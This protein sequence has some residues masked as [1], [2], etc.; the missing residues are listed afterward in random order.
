MLHVFVGVLA[1]VAILGN[2]NSNSNGKCAT[3]LFADAVAPPYPE[4]LETSR[5]HRKLH[6]SLFPNITYFSL[7]TLPS[8]IW[9][10]ASDFKKRRRL[11]R[12]GNYRALASDDKDF[13]D[14]EICRYLD[15]EAECQEMMER[16]SQMAAK[17]R[18]RIT[19]GNSIISGLR[20]FGAESKNKPYILRTLV[21]MVAWKEHENR[22]EWVSRDQVDHVW[23][24]IV[25]DDAIPTG[26][27]KHY[28]ETQSYGTVEFVA[29]VLDWRVAD[30]TEEYYAD[31]RSAMP[32]SGD[33]EPDIRTAFHKILEE[34]DSEDFPWGDYDSDNDGYVDHV[35][36]VHSGYGAELG[37]TDCYTKAKSDDRIWAH[38]LPEGRGKWTSPKTGIEL[39]G[40]SVSSVLRDKCGKEVAQLGVT[41]HEFYHTLGLP[42]LY[43]RELPY[44]GESGKSG[45]GGLGLFCMMACPFGA[46][47]NQ[48]H[49]G[50]LSP[51]SKV[52]MGFVKEP[53]EITKSGTYTARPSNGQP[54]IY[55][56]KKG[57]QDGEMLLLENR[58]NIGYDSSLWTGGILIY[59]IDETEGH[60]GNK[61]HGF[62]GQTDVPE[63]GQSWPSNGLH[64][65]IA[66][67]QADGD[68][69][70]E[71]ALNNGDRGDFFRKSNQKLGPGNG[72]LVATEEG[73]YPNTDSYAFGDIQTT[74][75]TIDDF[76][77]TPD[78]S[79]I[80][81]FRVTFADEP[82]SP[83]APPTKLPTKRPTKEPTG[84]PTEVPTQSMTKTPFKSPTKQPS[85]KPTKSPTKLP[86]AALTKSPAELP[87]K[88]PTEAPT[89]DS[90]S[91]NFEYWTS[92]PTKVPSKPPITNPPTEAPTSKQTLPF[93]SPMTTPTKVS[94]E[95]PTTKP[96][97]VAPTI[98]IET[99][100]TQSP[101]S[102]P[103]T[104]APTTRL[105]L[106]DPIDESECSHI[107]HVNITTDGRPEETKWEIVSAIT[108]QYLAG[109]R[110][111]EDL[112]PKRSLQTYTEYGWKI[113][114]WGSETS[115]IFRLHDSGFDG[116]QPPGKYSLSLNEELIA[117]GGPFVD[118]VTVEFSTTESSD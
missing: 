17:T 2:N 82:I 6:E 104:E 41:M 68:Y 31:G 92:K 8:G 94:T 56:I 71:N 5:K 13:D 50:S 32:R 4:L 24:G 95:P 93:E 114:S 47:N 113:C 34:M 76:R 29:D 25:T 85:E 77:E 51:W 84:K 106:I 21:I 10:P 48:M 67:L 96:P 38:A 52:E 66:L 59:H 101:S 20:T 99:P 45:L 23:N 117:S 98:P 58:Q 78:G 1:V 111:S 102:K 26:S 43:D 74:G 61:N 110:S 81:T 22:K 105:T 33:R 7:P 118:S 37:G 62:P 91:F 97:T 11:H 88:A 100:F 108:G 57:Y 3:I 60:N 39:G 19:G 16:F 90:T 89:P 115:F 12:E 72:E 73:T 116:L 64:Y 49:P 86:T 18:S 70:L 79:G 112:R 15:T 42:D 75:I 63:K 87:T 35:Q 28:T 27:I 14:D 9:E 107:L 55:A 30:N 46:N 80:F 40:F 83:S 103:P 54:D 65:A 109:Y 53:I 36:F 44:S 69:D